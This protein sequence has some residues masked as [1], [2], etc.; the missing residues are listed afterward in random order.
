MSKEKLLE[1]INYLGRVIEKLEKADKVR[2]VT[3]T[4]DVDEL[5]VSL[6]R[7]KE[8]KAEMEQSDEEYGY[9]IKRCII[10]ETNIATMQAHVERIQDRLT[11]LEDVMK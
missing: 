5:R 3:D 2:W 1:V 6:T 7:L 4:P 10:N 8:V 9:L 11:E